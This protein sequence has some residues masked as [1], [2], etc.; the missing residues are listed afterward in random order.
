MAIKKL[1]LLAVIGLFLLKAW[2]IG[3]VVIL[4][5]GAAIRRFFNKH[6]PPDAQA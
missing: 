4:A 1:G 5:G 6:S 3:L 2:K